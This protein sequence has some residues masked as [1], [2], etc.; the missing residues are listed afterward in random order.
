MIEARKKIDKSE[1]AKHER[2]K[3]AVLGLYGAGKSIE[4][5]AANL[6]CSEAVIINILKEFWR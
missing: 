3:T 6:Q 4:I 1:K 5:I 2:L